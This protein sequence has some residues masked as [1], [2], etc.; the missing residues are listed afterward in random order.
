MLTIIDPCLDHTNNHTDGHATHHINF[1]FH[2]QFDLCDSVE[3]YLIFT[4]YIHS[5]HTM[6]D[7]VSIW[8][9]LTMYYDTP[10]QYSDLV[11]PK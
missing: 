8:S 3:F 9:A 11:Q 7:S 2:H 1:P 10:I 4:R 6:N 5:V